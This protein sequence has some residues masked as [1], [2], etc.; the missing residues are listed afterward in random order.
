MTT[1]TLDDVLT[2]VESLQPEEQLTL[3]AR[4]AE[5]VRVVY[6]Q[7]P[8]QPKKLTI[9]ERLAEAGY[10]GGRLFKTAEE[11]DAYIREE[12]DSWER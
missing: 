4:L 5:R 11:V 10:T 8:P 9:T 7:Q 3:L 12:R 2:Q 6:S 1:A